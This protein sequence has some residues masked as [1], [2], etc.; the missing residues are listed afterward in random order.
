MFLL[1]FIDE[2]NKLKNG[3]YVKTDHFCET[4]NECSECQ[5]F[6]EKA[7]KEGGFHMCP[8]GYSVWSDGKNIFVAF[9]EKG[10]YDKRKFLNRPQ[11]AMVFNPI[12]SRMEAENLIAASLEIKAAIK[13]YESESKELVE[14]KAITDNIAHEVKNLNLRIKDYCDLCNASIADLNNGQITENFAIESIQEYIRTIYECV[15]LAICRYSL[16]NYENNPNILTS[17]EK[18]EYTIYTKFDK[19]RYIYSQKNPVYINIVGTSYAKMKAYASL[20]LIPLLL[21]ENAVKYAYVP[22]GADKKDFPV[23]I[24]FNDN[25]IDDLSV[26]I[27][28]YSPYCPPAELEHLFEKNYR[29]KN[30]QVF[31]NNGSGIGLFFVKKLCDIHGIEIKIKSGPKKNQITTLNKTIEY[32]DFVVTL[33][34]HNIYY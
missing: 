13:S 1:P 2:N 6:H 29:G 9:K 15:S 21:I 27:K 24:I 17:G 20:D 12:L 30:A 14:S 34:F 4:H 31:T 11:K 19:I 25:G 10:T 22:S 28:S 7:R 32:A 5:L 3:C 23:E 26:Q 8:H 18:K 33:N 16:Y